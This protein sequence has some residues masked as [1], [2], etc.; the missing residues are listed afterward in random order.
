MRVGYLVRSSVTVGGAGPGA[1]TVLP[2]PRIS[3]ENHLSV[4]RWSLLFTSA[5]SGFNVVADRC[6]LC[7]MMEFTKQ[8]HTKLH[9]PYCLS[10]N[11][12]FFDLLNYQFMF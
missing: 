1:C 6:I 5:V 2:V 4:K 9:L 7:V 12:D 10:Q 3:K 8:L 11:C